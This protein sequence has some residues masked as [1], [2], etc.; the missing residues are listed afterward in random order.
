M[1]FR[2]FILNDI[3][4]RKALLDVMP[5][6]TENR[7]EKY[8]ATISEIL[9]IYGTYK[10]IVK[11]FIDYKYEKL[12]P[13]K[14]EFDT[15]EV[16]TKMKELYGILILGNPITSYFERLG[17][18]VLLYDLMHYYKKSLADINSALE[19][20]L[21]VFENCGIKITIDNFKINNHC[22]LY[23]SEFYN[24]YYKAEVKPDNDNYEKIYWL[25]PKVIEYI[26][27]CLR[28]ITMDYS[29]KL[30]SYA[31]KKFDSELKRLGYKN[32]DAVYED[33]VNCKMNYKQFF[34]EDEFDIVS[35]C[36]EDK[37]DINEY[38][39]GCDTRK[40]DYDFFMINK[41][42]MNSQEQ[43]IKFVNSIIK[44]RYN[45]E[46]YNN[47]LKFLPLIDYFKKTYP[48]S[49]EVS[50]KNKKN[51]V[52]KDKEKEIE[53]DIKNLFKLGVSSFK[54]NGSNDLVIIDKAKNDL[55]AQEEL[56]QK[57]YK[58]C[59][60]YNN[61][62]FDEKVK[63]ILKY[64][65]P[66]NDIFRIAISFPFFIRKH[67]KK[68]FNFETDDEVTDCFN[69]LLEVVYNPT[70]R[71]IDMIPIYVDKDIPQQL[72]NGY[73]FENL[74]INTDSFEET[75]LK[76]IFDK[77]ERI[78]RGLKVDKFELSIEEI[79]FLTKVTKLKASKVL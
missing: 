44:L 6:N 26:I 65:S 55:F 38:I 17:L 19:K 37:I 50:V 11:K 69:E 68:Q 59:I 71:I 47:Y 45:L 40:S 15:T 36:L 77:S 41:I 51:N 46:E 48:I 21:L 52:L 64:N 39:P 25:C 4:E 16:E 53:K 34:V 66:V 14:Y 42:D 63:G 75:N 72:M 35:L 13:E 60:D 30:D 78:V 62:Y 74:N 5:T 54:A 70:K 49:N 29:S 32:Y 20:Y 2:E 27:I 76:Q 7:K 28:N 33:Y 56:L 8:N 67:I 58:D 61:I 31:T 23:M 9:T 3:E 22:Y 10:D 18:D 1:N 43:V 24:K 73:R 12:L 57:I 79:D